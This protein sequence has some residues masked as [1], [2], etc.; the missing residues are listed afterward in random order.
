MSLGR[1]QGLNNMQKEEM[2]EL[3]KLIEPELEAEKKEQF[4]KEYRELVIKHGFDF[5]LQPPVIVKVSF[6]KPPIQP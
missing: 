4:L 5:G 1:G 2:E 6:I 3:N